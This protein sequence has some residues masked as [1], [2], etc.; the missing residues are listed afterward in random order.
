MSRSA[1]ACDAK[2]DV[3]FGSWSCENALAG[4][5]RR[6]DFGE[7]AG[8]CHLPTL[9]AFSVWEVLLARISAGL[10]GSA[11]GQDAWL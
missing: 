9:T 7:A 4:G 3:R 5:L 11:T 6:R 2:T 8:F 10:G 1:P